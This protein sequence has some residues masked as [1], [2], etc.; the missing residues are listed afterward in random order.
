MMM[1]K[2]L[3]LPVL[4]SLSLIFVACGGAPPPLDDS[5]PVCPEGAIWDGAQCSERQDTGQGSSSDGSASS[6]DDP[7]PAGAGAGE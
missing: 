4:A 5:K 1:Q 7:P 3:V 2:W 6:S